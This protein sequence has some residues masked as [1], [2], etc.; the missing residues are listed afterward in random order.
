MVKQCKS[1]S[2]CEFCCA[3]LVRARTCY[4][5]QGSLMLVNVAPLGH[6]TV[7]G[8][9]VQADLCRVQRY[10]RLGS[11]K[12]IQL[13]SSALISLHMPLHV[14]LTRTTCCDSQSLCT[15]A[16]GS[17]SQLHFTL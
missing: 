8:I 1:G 4:F 17:H 9:S 12:D 7:L 15:T 16:N 2:A 5:S 10:L 3:T 13:G 14:N 11:A 6:P